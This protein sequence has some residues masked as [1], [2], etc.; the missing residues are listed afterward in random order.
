[1]TWVRLDGNDTPSYFDALFASG[2]LLV[3]LHTVTNTEQRTR[4][5][6]RKMLKKTA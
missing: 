3:L 4:A 2:L 5:E 6:A 1:M